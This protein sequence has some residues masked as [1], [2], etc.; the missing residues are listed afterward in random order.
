[1]LSRRQAVHF[2]LAA[3]AAAGFGLPAYAQGLSTIEMFVPAAPGGGWDQTARSIELAM[4]TDGIVSNFQFEH[5][6]GAG[7]AVGLPKFLSSKRGKEN[8]VM[9]GGLVMVGSLLANKSPVKM[10]ELVPLARLTGEA[11]VLVVPSSSPFQ[12]LEDLTRAMKA[13]IG[14]V[15]IAGGSAGGSDHILA[16]MMAKALGLEP[17]RVAY[18]A[19]AGG[20]PAQAAILGAQVSAGISGYGEFSEQVKAGK[21]RVLAISSDK[22][23]PG[24]D[25]PTFK[26]QGVDVELF[27]WRGVFGAPGITAAQRAALIGLF[28]RMV[29]GPTWKSELEKRD[30]TGV[31]LSGDPFGAFL[32][33]EIERI[34][35]ILKDLGLTS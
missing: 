20:G 17:K 10:T 31:Y 15:S 21:M 13:D 34:A 25:A 28:D 6:P 27:N 24:I 22:R 7:G 9:V 23:L 16:G 8:A 33:A 35:G 18:V 5:A 19:F 4:R 12:K 11:L 29:A 30:W 14:K 2:G 26:E 3:G 1:M 32:T